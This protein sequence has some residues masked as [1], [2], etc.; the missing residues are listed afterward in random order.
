MAHKK[1]L[2]VLTSHDQLGDS[3]KKTGWYLPEVA[4]PYEVFK[5]NGFDVTFASPKGGKTPIDPESIEQ[6]KKDEVCRRF[7]EDPA[8]KALWENTKSLDQIDASQFTGIFY[9]GGHG[10]MYDLVDNVASRELAAKIYEKGGVVAAL[11]H[12]PAA[13]V[14]VM[15]KNGKYLV[16]G[17]QM[18]CFSDAEEREVKKEKFVPFLLESKLRE[19]GAILKPGENWSNTVVA[20]GRLVTGQNPAS[21]TD[22]AARMCQV[23]NETIKQA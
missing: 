10:P 6:F 17:N 9:A 12:G 16:E 18:V 7:L 8:L 13:L 22:A 3:G 2:L 15:L 4:H 21:A 23:I 5:K 20:S 14:N 11:C 1:V 19:R